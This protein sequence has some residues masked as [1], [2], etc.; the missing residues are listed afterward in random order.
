M[1]IIEISPNLR[2]PE[3]E[4]IFSFARSSGKGGQNVNKVNSKAVL[5]WSPSNSRFL[6]AAV[7]QRFIEKYAN[8]IS[9]EGLLIIHSDRYRDQPMNIKDAIDKLKEMLLSV[10]FAPKKRLKTRPTKSSRRKRIES[11]KINSVKK[12]L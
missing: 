2:L 12:Q 6:S 3:Y 7:K 8:Q 4:L 1:S 9:Q 11:K 5:A 10:E